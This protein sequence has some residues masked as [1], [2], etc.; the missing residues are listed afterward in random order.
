VS[1]E[2]LANKRAIP[3]ARIAECLIG[4]VFLVGAVLK[5]M[6]INLFAVQI[7]GYHVI[8]DKLMLGPVALVTLSVESALA[9][10]LLLGLRM[11]GLT[12]VILEGLL[13]VFTGLILYGWIFHDLEDCGCFGGFAMTPGISISKNV[14]LIALGAVAWLGY[15]RQKNS[16]EG[17]KPQTMGAM[18]LK[19]IVTLLITLGV[20]FYAAVDMEK[21]SVGPEG[22]FAQFIIETDEETYDLGEG[23]YLVALLSMDCEHC[24]EAVPQLN[25]LWLQLED[26]PVLSLCFEENEGDLEAFQAETTPNFPLHSFGDQKLLFWNLIGDDTPRIAYVVDGHQVLF[27]DLIPPDYEEL[28]EAIDEIEQ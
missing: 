25:D 10:A 8:P 27:W 14:V 21:I 12:F 3:L 11:R 19:A 2:S 4:L 17:I 20:V 24:K 13:L 18:V 28:M 15:H 26:L 9:M 7:A 6:D 1:S 5:A 16:L 22:P 23:K